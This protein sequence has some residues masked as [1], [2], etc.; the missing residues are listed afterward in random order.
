VKS[1]ITIAVEHG[2]TTDPLEFLV[3]AVYNA[4]D[5][6]N[7]PNYPVEVIEHTYK[8]DVEYTSVKELEE[9]LTS[10]HF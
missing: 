7:T 4:A 2:E 5:G 8:V 6:V 3:R 10:N 9:L 1:I